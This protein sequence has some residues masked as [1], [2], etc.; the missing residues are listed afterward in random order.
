MKRVKI[1][2][3]EAIEVKRAFVLAD[4]GRNLFDKELSLN[5]LQGGYDHLEN[6]IDNLPPEEL[7]KEIKDKV[8]LARYES[9]DWDFDS[10][11]PLGVVGPYPK[12]SELAIELTLGGIVSTARLFEGVQFNSKGIEGYDF[13]QWEN[14]ESERKNIFSDAIVRT[15]SIIKNIY[16]VRPNFPLILFPGGKIRENDYNM[17]ARENGEPECKVLKHDID[18]GNNRALSYVLAGRQDAP[19][20]VG[21][22]R[23]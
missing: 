16:F 7:D 6:C 21:K 14:P 20:F 11:V 18:D 13:S 23:D 22:Y 5:E 1:M 2:N 12:M 3:V 10:C 4:E 15:E 17:R 9:M 8:R 19:A